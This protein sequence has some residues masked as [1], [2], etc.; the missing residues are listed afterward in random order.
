MADSPYI[1][2]LDEEN[3]MEVVVE[4]SVNQPVLVDFW[5]EWC[6][7]CKS[8]MPILEKLAVEYNGAFI[9]AKLDTEAHQG[10][11]QQLGIKSLPTV[12]MFNKQQL[13]DEFMGALPETEVRA[14]LEKHGI[15]PAEGA[16]DAAGEEA[17]VDSTVSKAMALYE[18]GDV[19]AARELLTAEQ[20]AD[21]T[22][23]EVLLALGQVCVS[24]GDLETA[25]SCLSALPDEHKNTQPA[26]RLSGTLEL[27][28][29]ADTS[30][31]VQLLQEE[32]KASPDS[33]EIRYQLAISTALSGDVQA[34]MDGLLEL[35]QKDPEYNE[36]APRKQL[37][38]LFN[39]L[40]DDPLTGQYR[41]KLATLLN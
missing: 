5:A 4:G 6:G 8:L 34:G 19:E 22:N 40:G 26:N 41:R 25:A 37:L 35:V 29:E 16:A 3:F 7:P 1:I 36:G 2:P 39:V 12:K 13:V 27:A 33:S 28:K 23:A 14:F 11:A 24:T 15:T 31:T 30:K 38:S 9:L 32:L 21:P 18:Q 10:I 20:A 17:P